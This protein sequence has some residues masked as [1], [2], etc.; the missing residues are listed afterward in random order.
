[1]SDEFKEDAESVKAFTPNSEIYKDLVDKLGY[2]VRSDIDTLV[3]EVYG[4]AAMAQELGVIT[5]DQF[6]KINTIAIRNYAN[7]GTHRHERAERAFNEM[8]W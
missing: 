8:E 5:W 3:S 6:W 2:A 1:M 7:G 4:R